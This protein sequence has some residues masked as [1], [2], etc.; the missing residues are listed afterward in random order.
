MEAAGEV[1]GLVTPGPA[2]SQRDQ[3]R[4]RVHHEGTVRV[5]VHGERERRAARALPGER[6]ELHRGLPLVVR[7]LPDAE[8]GRRRVEEPAHRRGERRMQF[9]GNL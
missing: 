4:T 7:H 8:D 9:S 6:L 5:L 2:L 3:E 1:G